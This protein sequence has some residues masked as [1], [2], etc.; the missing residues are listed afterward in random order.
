MIDGEQ[1]A[2]FLPARRLLCSREAGWRNVLV[3]A[4]AKPA[5]VAPFVI[6]ATSD[7]RLVLMLRGHSRV[8]A[9]EAGRWHATTIVPGHV[10]MAAPGR[11]EELQW[12][13]LSAEPHECLHVHL[14]QRLIEGFIH[15]HYGKSCR[16]QG[17]PT[18]VLDDPI[19]E[20]VGRSLHTGL[21]Q[22]ESELYAESA[23]Q[24][25]VARLLTRQGVLSE[26]E[27]CG[28]L[29]ARRL[30]RVQAYMR[31]RLA[32]P[33]GLDA[34][35]READVS[36]YHFLRRFKASTGQTPMR[37]L[38]ALRMA[39][40]CELLARTGLG[41]TEIALECGYSNPAHFATAFRRH[42]GLAPL[43]FRQRR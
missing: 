12:S 26:R 30:R 21:L 15:R 1:L 28:G 34:L 36:R 19:V 33:I 42:T 13:A 7:L 27:A 10:S 20:H 23:L 6:P 4:Y 22:G 40:A 41:V 31:E 25:L 43:A 11:E 14:P 8:S 29:D 16:F 39:H 17:M 37:Y 3:R 2:N 9:R 18:V 24:Y 32:E 35:A 5:R 38:T